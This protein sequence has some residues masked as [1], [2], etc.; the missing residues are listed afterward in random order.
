[1][2]KSANSHRRTVDFNVDDYVWLNTKYW[3][4]VRPSLKLDNKNSGPFKITAKEGNS[5]RL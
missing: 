2:I 1:M 5:F 4:T 3:N